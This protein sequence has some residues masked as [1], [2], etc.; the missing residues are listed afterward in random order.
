MMVNGGESGHVK[1]G[2]KG[3]PVRFFMPQQRMDPLNL[4][5]TFMIFC[6]FSPHC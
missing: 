3:D 6:H 2:P 5:S 1:K 4:A